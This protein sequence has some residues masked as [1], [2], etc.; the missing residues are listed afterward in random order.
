[1]LGSLEVLGDEGSLP[2]A[3]QRQ[4]ALLAILLLDAGRVVPTDRLIDQLWGE[5]PPATAN[6][7]LHNAISQLRRLLGPD[8][9]ETRSPGYVLRVERETIDAVRFERML[10]EARAADAEAR[11]RLIREALG[12]WRGPALA[13]FTF[14]AWAQ[15]EANRLEELRLARSSSGSTPIS[16]SAGT[17]TSSARSRRSSA[18]IRCASRSGAS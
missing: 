4:R 15:P 17:A 2:L 14:D 6:T 8:A 5:R 18:S 1:M 9:V 12:L 13:E 11:A 3:G 16:S 10:R 7:S